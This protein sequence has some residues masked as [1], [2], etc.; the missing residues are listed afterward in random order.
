MAD[1]SKDELDLLGDDDVEAFSD[2]QADLEGAAENLFS[3]PPHPQPLH[4]E[5]LSLKTP[6][7]VPHP[8]HGFTT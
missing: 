7:T 5:T 8:R 3:S 4:F 6:K 2:S 1:T